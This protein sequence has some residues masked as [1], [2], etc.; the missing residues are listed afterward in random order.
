[1]RVAFLAIKAFIVTAVAALC[2]F[3]AYSLS[4]SPVFAGGERYEFYR[5]TSSDEIV[6]ARFPYEKLFLSGIKGESARFK[7]DRA[8]ELVARFGAEILFTEEAAGVVN[9][10]CFTPVLGDA[11]LLGESA[12]NLHIA[13]NGEETAA[14]TPVIFGGF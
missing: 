5:G 9:Y 4:V 6:L 12:V 10:Y 11:V 3:F 2:V 7:G 14:G 8:E 1:M 13:C